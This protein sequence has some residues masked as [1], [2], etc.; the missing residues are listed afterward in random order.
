MENEGKELKVTEQD[1]AIVSK[2]LEENEEPFPIESEESQS[3]DHLNVSEEFMAW[4][5]ARKKRLQTRNLQEKTEN[6]ERLSHR[7]RNEAATLERQEIQSQQMQQAEAQEQ[8][9]ESSEPL[10]T[11][12][13]A[14][15]EYMDFQ[16][17]QE[18]KYQIG[19]LRKIWRRHITYIREEKELSTLSKKICFFYYIL[20]EAGANCKVSSM[21]MAFGSGTASMEFG[22]NE[23][24]MEGEGKKHIIRAL[25]RI[26]ISWLA[27]AAIVWV[28]LTTDTGDRP[29]LIFVLIIGILFILPI[30]NNVLKG[31]WIIKED[32]VRNGKRKK[33]QQ[34]TAKF[35]EKT[36]DFCLEKLISGLNSKMLRLIFADE[37][38]EI[39][40]IADGDMTGFLQ[41]Q[42]NV[43]ECDIRNIW[44]SDLREDRDN[45]Y[46]DVTYQVALDRDM[47]DR[48]EQGFKDQ[49]V[50]LQLTRPVLGM[51][52][53]DLY[54]DWKIVKI[55]V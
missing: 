27:L 17:L 22:R 34:V 36:P 19:C 39:R 1:V 13:N 11:L 16:L 50:K 42:A 41:D 29:I 47:G 18:G 37:P 38:E 28:W 4:F 8:K 54:R 46:L 9:E 30:I 12:Q 32:M 26:L 48:I 43:V 52:E 51:N 3:S 14:K 7:Q 24:C 6:I 33:S 49:L 45:M 25:C 31:P 53:T 21:L 35:F 5:Q 55:E 2:I 23:E 40:D 20:K 15:K 10:S 44:F